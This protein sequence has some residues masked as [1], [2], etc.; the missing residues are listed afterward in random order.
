MVNEINP[1]FRPYASNVE[2]QR[3]IIK[4]IKSTY[5]FK[6]HNSPIMA[7]DNFYGVALFEGFRSVWSINHLEVLAISAPLRSAQHD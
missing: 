7:L 5:H 3:P 1:C 4:E 6:S 2:T